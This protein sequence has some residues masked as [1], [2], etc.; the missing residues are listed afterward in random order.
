MIQLNLKEKE[1][2]SLLNFYMNEL[3]E[4]NNRIVEINKVVQLLSREINAVKVPGKRGRKPGSGKVRK[5]TVKR[6]YGKYNW[7]QT[8]TEILAKSKKP[9]GSQA[10]LDKAMKQFKLDENAAGKTKSAIAQTIF[11]LKKENKIIAQKTAK[12]REKLYSLTAAE[13]AEAAG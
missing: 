11:R 4:I 13:S 9:M 3:E 7:N 2:K 10:I 6:E 12:G 5:P 1:A 8:I